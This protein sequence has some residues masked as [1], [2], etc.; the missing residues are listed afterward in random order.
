MKTQITDVL[1]SSHQVLDA[2]PDG[3]LLVTRSGTILSANPAMERLS[4][5]SAEQLVGQSVGMFLPAHLREKH[6]L[7]VDAFFGQPS[8]RPMGRV[9]QLQ[10]LRRNGSA[11]PIDIALGSLTMQDQQVAAVFIRDMTELR[12]LQE[13]MSHQATHDA[14]TGLSNRWVFGLQLEQ[15]LQ[16]S[17]RH[18]RTLGLL[19]LDLDDFKTIN[20]GHGHGVG[21]LV[22]VEV[23]R[24][25]QGVMRVSD[26][27]AR[28]GGD[29]F[30]VLLP[31]LS[32]PEDAHTVAQK[33][34]LALAVPCRVQ[35]YLVSLSASIGLACC[36]H[37]AADAD[38]LMRYADM[39]MYAAKDA[40]RGTYRVYAPPMG[41]QVEQNMQLHERLRVALQNDRLALHYQPQIDVAHG[42]VV[43][44][45]A[46][47]RWH[48]D[49]LGPVPPNRFVPVAVR[50]GLM[51]ELGE[52][53]LR[54][55]CRQIATWAAA[56]L[57]IRVSVNVSA[58]QFRQPGLAERLQRCLTEY[59]VAPEWLE[60]EI[61]ESEAMA[62]TQLACE[63]LHQ[64]EAMGVGVALDDFGT[65]YSSLS[66]LRQLP[67]SR[68]KID[69]AFVRD[70]ATNA[71]DATLVR[72]VIA[73]A[74]T[75]GLPVVAEGVENEHQLDFLRRHGC[76]ICQGWL[77][78]PALPA[79]EVAAVV[80]PDHCTEQ[81]KA[82]T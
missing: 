20:D 48:D 11:I 42:T 9:G 56:G 47:L 58:Q 15:A 40:G 31:G 49:V 73:L 27:L 22:L 45:E 10:L 17:L 54:T 76:E 38:T 80:W 35:G 8:A 37:D 24:R 78:H 25:L 79:D 64:L 75:M 30:T 70:I 14:L 36:P 1:V 62:D 60:L 65:G 26:I 74:H 46:L 53:V 5:Y 7:L 19:L 34:L 16:Q 41:Q 21:D 29:E 81:R 44:L 12:R 28:Q 77:F 57:F 32:C 71:G 52:W 51:L 55:A 66:Y 72:A 50:Y 2:A 69:R 63:V 61:T 67:V 13:Q 68:L 3:I 33:L 59:G 23:A 6:T 18:K 82:G 39:A 4:G 43:G